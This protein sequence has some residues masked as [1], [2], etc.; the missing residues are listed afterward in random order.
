MDARSRTLAADWMWELWRELGGEIPEYIDVHIPVVDLR[1]R[2]PIPEEIPVG[3]PKKKLSAGMQVMMANASY[4]SGGEGY[5]LVNRKSIIDTVLAL[6]HKIPQWDEV[7]A[8][9]QEMGLSYELAWRDQTTLDWVREERTSQGEN[10]EWA[11][12][13]GSL[14]AECKKPSLLEFRA[15]VH[16]PTT[17]RMAHGKTLQEPPAIEGFLWR[18]KAVSGALTRLYVTTHDGHIFICRPTRAF[19]P[20]RHLASAVEEGEEEERATLT[21]DLPR[22]QTGEGMDRSEQYPQGSPSQRRK[23]KDVFLGRKKRVMREASLANLRQQVMETVTTLASTEEEVDAQIEAYRAFEKRRQFEQITNADGYVDLRDITMVKSLGSGPAKRPSVNLCEGEEGNNDEKARDSAS[24]GTAPGAE[25][26]DEESSGAEPE[27]VGG[28]EGLAASK[29]RAALRKERQF[30]VTMSNGRSIRFEAYS[31]S[32]AHEW[33]ERLAALARYWKRRE[34]VDALERMNACGYDPTLI[35]R[36]WQER[37]G[38]RPMGVAP[39]VERVAPLLGNIWNWCLVQGCRGILRSGRLFHKR[40]AYAPFR[41]RHY[42]LIAGRLLHYKLMTSNRTARARQ[43]S[44]I[45]HR[46]QET[47][48]HLRDAYVYSGKLTEDMLIN[49]RSEGAGAIG[50]FGPGTGGAANSSTR[51]TL[52]R[53]YGDGM[54]SVDEDEECTFVVR[55]RPERVN[56]PAQP[57]IVVA[58][59]DGTSTAA[60]AS[61][62]AGTAGSLSGVERTTMPASSSPSTLPSLRDKKHKDLVLRARSKLERDL[63]VRAISLEIERLVREDGEREEKIRQMGKTPYINKHH[64]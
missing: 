13:C 17:V 55:Y 36:R 54:M 16:Y 23:T 20:D 12:L 6:G 44:G 30:E 22:Q 26:L 29:D 61:H 58:Q 46:R 24:Q 59:R 41:S 32:V 18:V 50:A 57:Q 34:K 10:R 33:I 48:V 8:K 38:D 51:H 43:N 25:T 14:L 42:L 56:Q 11:V 3:V 27:D 47:V 2:I 4:Q 9:L 19:P 39:D 15:A 60:I 45:F 31:K 1:V 37:P 64:H 52:P 49:G 7:T 40:K 21:T 35:Q 28:E 5:K 62:S 63:W 53:M